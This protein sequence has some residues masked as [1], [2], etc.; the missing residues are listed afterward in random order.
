MNAATGIRMF[1][2]MFNAK[3]DKEPSN[4]ANTRGSCL[5]SSGRFDGIEGGNEQKNLAGRFFYL[6]YKIYL[7]IYCQVIYISRCICSHAHTR[8]LCM[9]ILRSLHLPGRRYGS[10]RFP[11]IALAVRAPP[12]LDDIFRFAR[13]LVYR[14]AL[15]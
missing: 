7:Y 13:I 10:G 5:A 6:K 12:C 4:I 11:L 8:I 2:R 15:L 3:F 1:D 9:T 14:F